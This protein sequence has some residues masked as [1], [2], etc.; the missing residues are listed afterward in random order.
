[1]PVVRETF[2]KQHQ[3]ASRERADGIAHEAR[4]LPRREQG[5]FHL[6][7][8]V[9][10]ITLPLDRLRPTRSQDAFDVP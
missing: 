3:V 8:E 7:M 9:P 4:A 2:A 1:M 6:L 10:V 5:Q